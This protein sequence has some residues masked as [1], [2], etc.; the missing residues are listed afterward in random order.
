M[1][2]FKS[3][4]LIILL[5]VALILG[6]FVTTSCSDE[7]TSVSTVGTSTKTDANTT[8]SDT[9]AVKPDTKLING[10]IPTQVTGIRENIT[11]GEVRSIIFWNVGKLG[12]EQYSK[13]T[14]TI[15]KPDKYG[16]MNPKNMQTFEGYFTGGP[17]G[18]FFLSSNGKN[19]HANMIEDGTGVRLDDGNVLDIQNPEAFNG[20]TD[21]S[22]EKSTT[23]TSKPNESVS[24]TSDTTEQATAETT[25]QDVNLI[26]GVVPTK[27]T[28]RSDVTNEF[29][30][31]TDSFE[32][33]NVGKL[34]GDQYTKATMKEVLIQKA[35]DVEGPDNYTVTGEGSFTGGP[36][37]DIYISF[38]L[39]GV[40]TKGHAKLKDGKEVILDD[41]TIVTI[42][43]PEAFKGWTD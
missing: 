17:N 36:N 9:T 20:W 26:H 34:G 12:G 7:D 22:T 14:Y 35:K 39:E 40:T 24:N 4:I 38:T 1:K 3:F 8:E 6:A 13:A 43:N 28:A 27:V 30:K 16:I 5:I 31:F 2:K 33:W 10:V 29:G 15:N 18:E 42:D 41:G 11:T 37:G 32:F 25:K 19:L 23:D 21:N